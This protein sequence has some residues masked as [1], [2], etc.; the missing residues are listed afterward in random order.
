MD[1]NFPKLEIDCC[2]LMP[3]NQTFL[4][5]I[6]EAN[7]IGEDFLTTDIK[8]IYDRLKLLSAEEWKNIIALGEQTKLFE[9]KEISNIKYVFSKIL[10]K[11]MVNQKTIPNFVK[12]LIVFNVFVKHKK[13]LKK[14]KK[15]L[16]N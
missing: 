4:A 5:K 3:I 14:L 13:I 11:D 1:E 16:V 2:E 15:D 9:Y 12:E 7:L 6:E 10:K 8:P